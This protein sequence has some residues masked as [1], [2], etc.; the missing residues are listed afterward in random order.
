M[1]LEHEV[2][3]MMIFDKYDKCQS[4]VKPLLG[5]HWE[6]PTFQFVNII[7]WFARLIYPNI[8]FPQMIYLLTFQVNAGIRLTREVFFAWSYK[9]LKSMLG[10]FTCTVC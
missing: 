2:L 6:T 9:Q 1:L 5:K 3:G 10:Q 7:S 8:S 4:D